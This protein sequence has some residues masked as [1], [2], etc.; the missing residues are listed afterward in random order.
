M[1]TSLNGINW[2]SYIIIVYNRL[3]RLKIYDQCV[4]WSSLLTDE[5]WNSTIYNNIFTFY[6][7]S[8]GIYE[9]A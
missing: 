7:E 6:E 2:L 5:N 3:S 1:K 9:F 8:L 4:D